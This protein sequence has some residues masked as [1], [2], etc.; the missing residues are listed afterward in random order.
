MTILWRGKGWG[1]SLKSAILSN[2]NVLNENPDE[3]GQYG[4]HSSDWGHEDGDPARLEGVLDRIVLD[5]DVIHGEEISWRFEAR[6]RTWA[7]LSLYFSPVNSTSST[8]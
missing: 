8:V 5:L 7:C 1:A 6:F 2:M 3:G 4:Q